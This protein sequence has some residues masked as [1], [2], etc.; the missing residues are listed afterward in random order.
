MKIRK[1]VFKPAVK[2]TGRY[3]KYFS[4][5]KLLIY[6]FSSRIS[7]KITG[8][9]G[10]GFTSNL[11]KEGRSLENKKY[12]LINGRRPVRNILSLCNLKAYVIVCCADGIPVNMTWNKYE[13]EYCN[14]HLNY[15]QMQHPVCYTSILLLKP[16]NIVFHTY[17]I[18]WKL[19]QAS[20]VDYN[21]RRLAL[22]L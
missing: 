6:R 4:Y 19:V 18:T 1:Y 13:L 15:R 21:I 16:I 9:G 20:R 2:L 14:I 5:S 11:N 22:L 12:H 7:W 17:F 8:G 3:K 10:R